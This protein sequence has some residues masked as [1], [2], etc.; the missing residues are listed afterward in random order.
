MFNG[1]V[2]TRHDTVN[3]LDRA[4]LVAKEPAD[5]LWNHAAHT[6]TGTSIPSS[7]Q[8]FSKAS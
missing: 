8:V 1:D 3:L 4:V 2:V 5:D 6:N 7:A